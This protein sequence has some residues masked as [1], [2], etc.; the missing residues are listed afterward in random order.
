VGETNEFARH[1]EYSD[2][3]L[4]DTGKQLREKYKQN[5]RKDFSCDSKF[6]LVPGANAIDLDLRT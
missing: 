5:V 1:S 2:N 3:V 6:F 4:I